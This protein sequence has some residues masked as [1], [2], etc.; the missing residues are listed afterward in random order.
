MFVSL[1]F[2][3]PSP[4]RSAKGAVSIVLFIVV[5]L[6]VGMMIPASAHGQSLP[7]DSAPSA[8]EQEIGRVPEWA[9]PAPYNRPRADE[10]PT[11]M[12]NPGEVAPQ[13][14][15]HPSPDP[16]PVDGGLGFLIAA[17]GAYAIRTLRA[18]ASEEGASS[19]D[20]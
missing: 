19:D 7:T 18:N 8:S 14:G 3:H 1:F 16:I 15:F 5:F 4:T 6:S 13:N 12:P 2:Q 11:P 9:E 10:R 17:G 20:V